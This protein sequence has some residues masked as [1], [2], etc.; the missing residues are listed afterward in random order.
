MTSEEWYGANIKYR[1]PF[2]P[3]ANRSIWTLMN[4]TVYFCSNQDCDKTTE[5]YLTRWISVLHRQVSIFT[6][7]EKSVYHPGELVRIRVMSL[8]PEMVS[9]NFQLTKYPSKKLV[10]QSNSGKLQLLPLTAEDESALNTVKC[11]EV[12]VI[13]TADE[14]VKMW[15]DVSFLEATDLRYYLP[16]TAQSGEWT[17]GAT[18]FGKTETAHFHVQRHM[19]SSLMVTINPSENLTVDSSHALFTVCSHRTNG[20][21]SRGYVRAQICRCPRPRDMEEQK[22]LK[23]AVLAKNSCPF[24]SQTP[25]NTSGCIEAKEWLQ[26]DGCAKF[27]LQT[28]KLVQDTSTGSKTDQLLLIC[29][30]AAE[31]ELADAKGTRCVFDIGRRER[32]A[33]LKLTL[34]SVYNPGLPT[35]GTVSLFPPG[36]GQ[37]WLVWGDAEDNRELQ[38]SAIKLNVTGQASFVIPP[39]NLP[40]TLYVEAVCISQDYAN[41]YSPVRGYNGNGPNTLMTRAIVSRSTDSGNVTLQLWP[42]AN[43]AQ[44]NC[45]GKLKLLVISNIPLWNKMFELQ[46]N[47][48]GKVLHLSVPP[49]TAKP[50]DCV[51]Q[52]GILGHYVC[53]HSQ[54]NQISCLPGWTGPDCMITICKAHCYPLGGRCDF[55]ERCA[56]FEGW[57]GANCDVCVQ[58]KGCVHGKCVNGSDCVCDDGWEGDLCDEVQAHG[59]SSYTKKQYLPHPTLRKSGE[60]N[61]PKRTI[62]TR[63]F[64]FELSNEWRDATT[65][66]LYFYHRDKNSVK[67]VA[68][69]FDMP[70]TDGCSELGEP[71]FY[72]KEIQLDK[73]HTYAGQ[74]VQLTIQMCGSSALHSRSSVGHKEQVC[75]MHASETISIK[76][77]RLARI[78]F[79]YTKTELPQ[80]TGM[81]ESV[82]NTKVLGT[83]G[84]LLLSSTGKESYNEVG[85]ENVEVDDASEAP[86]TKANAIASLMSEYPSK[87]WLFEVWHLRQWNVNSVAFYGFQRNITAPDAAATW[88]VSAV[89]VTGS[90]GL[91]VSP[92]QTLTV[93]RPFAV[94]TSVSK[95]VKLTEDPYISI[96]VTAMHH[97]LLELKCIPVTV[98]STSNVTDWITLGSYEFT[99]CVCPGETRTF[100][101]G[102]RP[103]RPGRLEVTAS[104]HAVFDSPLCSLND[105]QSYLISADHEHFMV[106]SETIRVL[107]D[108]Y[109]QH[110]IFG[111]L[112]CLHSGNGS[113]E[114][115]FSFTYPEDIVP[116]SL[117]INLSYVD[118]LWGRALLNVGHLVALP[119]SGADQNLLSV[120]SSL[121]LL[122]YLQSTRIVNFKQTSLL[123]QDTVRHIYAGFQKLRKYRHSDGSYSMFGESDGE[124]STW[125]TAHVLHTVA[126][127]RDV[128]G[129]LVRDWKLLFNETIQFLIKR[130]RPDGSGCFEERSRLTNPKMQGRLEDRSKQYQEMV[131]SAYVL[132]V[133]YEVGPNLEGFQVPSYIPSLNLGIKC[134][135]SG[136]LGMMLSEGR[137]DE[138]PTYDLAMITNTMTLLR[139]GDS[140]T[141]FLLNELLDRKRSV[142]VKGERLYTYW[143]A[144]RIT[145]KYNSDGAVAM[146]VATTSLAYK[147]L[148]NTGLKFPELF[149][150]A[151][152]LST[153]QTLYGGFYSIHDTSLGL[154]VIAKEA[155]RLAVHRTLNNLTVEVY[156][157][158][159][160]SSWQMDVTENNRRVVNQIEVPVDNSTIL[161]SSRWI[162]SSASESRSDCLSVQTLVQYNSYATNNSHDSVYQLFVEIE[163]GKQTSATVYPV[164]NVTVC[165][166]P[167]LAM[168]PHDS[169]ILLLQVSMVS[170]WLPDEKKLLQSVG[171]KEDSVRSVEIDKDG[172][173]AFLFNGFTVAEANAPSQN[174]WSNLTRCAQV[175]VRQTAYVNNT[176]PAQ[177]KVMEYY[178]PEISAWTSFSLNNCE[179]TWLSRVNPQT[180]LSTTE[181]QSSASSTASTFSSVSATCAACDLT[182]EKKNTLTEN[183]YKGL[184][185]GHN[186]ACLLDILSEDYEEYK[187]TVS[188]ASAFDFPRSWNATLKMLG[189]LCAAAVPGEQLL[190]FSAYP[191]QIY[192]G[193]LDVFL[194]KTQPYITVLPLSEVLSHMKRVLAYWGSYSTRTVASGAISSWAPSDVTFEHMKSSYCEVVRHISTNS[195]I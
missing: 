125:L 166:R 76:Y 2:V 3:V 93:V 33:Q 195:S 30:H 64:E 114:K 74:A 167:S 154:E 174:A 44:F 118:E 107:Q 28:N 158:P 165:F 59:Y 91:W 31:G 105:Q 23:Q 134:L 175:N 130:H 79:S 4:F 75:F 40:K 129:D 187:V 180:N 157:E 58:R 37:V 47:V 144:G 87:N 126:A 46:A 188:T 15:R 83:S 147:A 52:D 45:S 190:I 132:S 185:I 54:G 100:V 106:V 19:F 155:K 120:S 88:Q 73:K 49:I 70:Q 26:L 143:K 69:T 10:L 182:E 170:G 173:V 192:P 189:C 156:M 86:N 153:Q 21:T 39:Q 6:E 183:I 14:R 184:C 163:Q 65:P 81:Y 12:F 67:A 178:S 35:S 82:G 127:L 96:S 48:W 124:G 193:D 36:E 138:I 41:S 179:S 32:S 57:T 80:V 161:N 97:D 53:V 121:F 42:T 89:C 139:S 43:S 146:D 72:K 78:L 66:V 24:R 159:Y 8:T 84:I 135:R 169:G 16:T 186:K 109:P 7:I 168:R 111:D 27:D 160:G 77:D 11:S 101:L 55:M 29:A 60:F 191:L 20:Q 94:L 116:D 145:D 150:I 18:V 99:E 92:P 172:T 103:L 5:Q 123:V 62:F 151:Q 95:Q 133:L 171:T 104:V 117:T 1:A 61:Q 176:Q 152:W 13:N 162:M 50:D 102:L 98:T 177:I 122:D 22:R 17:V 34:P 115:I 137:F 112:I 119:T 85:D 141:T 128:N 90:Y 56:C 136:P 142:K 131:L 181:L 108:G 149:S 194:R 63:F 9:P 68:T 113:V 51:D 71:Q 148:V 38:A 25:A 164:A 140:F 110:K